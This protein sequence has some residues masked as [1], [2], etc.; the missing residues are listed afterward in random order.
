M[1]VVSLADYLSSN[2]AAKKYAKILS[3]CINGVRIDG[4]IGKIGGFE[5]NPAA[6]ASEIR[7]AHIRMPSEQP[8]HHAKEQPFRSSD[9]F[10]IYCHHHEISDHYH[11]IAIVTPDAHAKIDKMLFGICEYAEK[12]FHNLNSRELKE[13]QTF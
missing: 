6:C 12:N 7:K 9:N 5:R 13:L 1:A 8:W 11:I 4:R 10:L 2:P 3:D